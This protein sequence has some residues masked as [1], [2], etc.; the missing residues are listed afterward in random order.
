MGMAPRRARVLPPRRNPGRLM[1]IGGGL[2]L[3]I[4][5]VVVIVLLVRRR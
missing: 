4:V 5:V 2:L 3:F 1:Y